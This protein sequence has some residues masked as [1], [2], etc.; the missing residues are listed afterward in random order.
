MTELLGSSERRRRYGAAGR[1][2]VM[3]HFSI[4][5]MVQGNLAVYRELLG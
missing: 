5:S 2:L 3:A 4:D 1:E